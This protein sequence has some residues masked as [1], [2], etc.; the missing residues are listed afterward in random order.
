VTGD[1]VQ[2]GTT[3]GAVVLAASWSLWSYDLTLPLVSGTVSDYV[4]AEPTTPCIAEVLS[5]L[6]DLVM[7]GH[8]VN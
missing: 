6:G 5:K 8:I 1:E 2:K 3:T 7:E 4:H